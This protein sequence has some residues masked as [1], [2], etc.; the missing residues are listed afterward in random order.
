MFREAARIFRG[1]VVAVA[2]GAVS[3]T[4]RGT[5]RGVR[6]NPLVT[7]KKNVAPGQYLPTS[8]ASIVPADR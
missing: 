6:R 5:V 8:Y 1:A 2:A 7:R 4:A 3:G